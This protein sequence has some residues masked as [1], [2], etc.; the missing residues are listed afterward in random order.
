MA[1]IIEGKRRMVM[2]SVDDV[3]SV[4]TQYQTVIGMEKN[5][6]KVRN[7]LKQNVFYLPEDLWFG[8]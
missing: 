4:I 5:Y 2:M 7:I 1:K 8:A 3:L 6:E